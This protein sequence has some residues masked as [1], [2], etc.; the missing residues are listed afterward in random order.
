MRSRPP[1]GGI[2]RLRRTTTWGWGIRALLPIVL[3]LAGCGESSSSGGDDFRVDIGAEGVPAADKLVLTVK[4]ETP[5]GRVVVSRSA[6][7][8]NGL[9]IDRPVQLPKDAVPPGEGPLYVHAV[10]QLEGRAV[11]VTDGAVGDGAEGRFTLKVVPLVASCD[12]DGDTYRDCTNVRDECCVDVPEATRAAVIDCVDDPA[13]IAPPVTPDGKRRRAEAAHGFAPS[14]NA[15]DYATCGNGLDDDCRGGDLACDTETDADGDQ[16]PIA[17]D[18]NDADDQIHVGAYDRPGDGVDQDCDGI[19][20][21][22]TDEDEDGWLADDPDEARRDCADDDP[23]RFPAA[24]EVPCDGIDQDCD[25]SDPCPDMGDMDADGVPAAVDCDDYDAGA[26]PGARERCG[27]GIDQDCNGTDLACA[28]GDTDRD[29]RVGADDCDEGNAFVHR[30][31]PEKCGDGV[32]QDCDGAD[33]PCAGVRDGDGDGFAAPADCDDGAAEVHPFADELCN[34]IDDDCDGLLDEGSPLRLAAGDVPRE[35]TCG[36]EGGT[37]FLGRNVCTRDQV[38]GG[39]ARPAIVCLGQEP[40]PEV[41]DGLDNDCDGMSDE[42]DQEDG[43]LSDEGLEACGPEREMGGCR[44]GTLFCEN[45]SLSRCVGAVFP[46][47]EECNGA[48]D[49]CDGRVDNDAAGGALTR[50]CFDGAEDLRNQGLC[51]DG[52]QRCDNGRFGACEGQV[53]PADETCDTRDEDCDGAADDEVLADCYSFPPETRGVGVCAA[54]RRLCADGVFGECEGEVGPS[55]EQCNNRDDDCDGRIDQ[56]AERCF[57]GDPAVIDVGR[58]RAGERACM[59][60]NWTECR[61]QIVPEAETCD[62]EDDDCDGAIDEDF[63]LLTDRQNCNQCGR[64]CGD[65]EECCQ[66]R[67][68]RLDTAEN[69]GACGNSCDRRADRCE[70]GPDSARCRC[71]DGDACPDGQRCVDGQCRCLSNDDCGPDQL[72]CNGACQATRVEAGP[73]GEPA[74]CAACGDGGCNPRFAEHCEERVC[75][76]GDTDACTGTTVCLQDDDDGE[77]L[78]FGCERDR[79]CLQAGTICCRNACVPV[80][81]DAQCEACGERCSPTAADRCVEVGRNAEPPVACVCGDGRAPCAA[82]TPF[83]IGGAC[84]E[85]RNDADCPGDRSRCVDNVCRECNPADH[86]PCGADQLCCNFRCQATGPT[87]GEQCEACGEACDQLSTNRCTGRDCRCGNNPE[88]SGATPICDDARGVCVN[89]RN[90]TDCQGNPNGGQ[91]VN[92]VCRTCDP[93]GHDGCAGNQLCCARGGVPRCE[94]TGS[95]QGDE[96]EACDVACAQAPTNACNGRS[97]GCGNGPPCGGGTPICDDGRSLCVECLVD[98]HCNNRPGG[99]Q[100]VN[101]VCRPCDPGDHAGCGNDQLCC[102]FQCQATSGAVNGQC[103]ACGQACGSSADTC[104]NRD[105][106]CG[107]AAGAAACGDPSPF[108]QNGACQRCRN[109][110]DCAGNELCC[111]GACVPTGAEAPLPCTACGTSC[112]ATNSNLCTN[113]GCRCGVNNACGGASP[114]CNDAAGRC[115]QCLADVDCNGRAGTPECVGETCRAC[116]PAT[117]AGCAE[118]GAM[119][120]CDAGN[121]TCRTCNG[122]AECVTR[123]GNQNECV[124]GRCRACEP[125]TN[126]GCSDET[127]TCDPMSFTCRACANN[128]ECTAGQQCVAGACVGCNPANG[129]GCGPDQPICEAGTFVCRTCRNDN[130]CGARTGP[131]DQCVLG[132]CQACDTADHAGCA[133]NQLCCNFQCQATGAAAPAACQAC[134]VSCNADSTNTCNGRACR[135]GNN[136]PCSGQTA[137]CDD[138]RGVCVNCRDDDDC[139]GARGECVSN[140]CEACDP[141]DDSGCA[142]NSNTPICAGATPACRACQNDA[143]CPNNGQCLADG[144]CRPCDPTNAAGCGEGSAAPICDAANATCRACANDGECAAR[145][146]TLDWCVQGE[147]EACKPADNSGC[148]AAS[149]TPICDAASRTCRAC[150]NDVDCNGNP[151]GG[152]CVAGACKPCDPGDYAGCDAASATPVCNAAFACVGCTLDPQCVTSPGN[153]DQCVAGGRCK[154]CDT[155]DHAGCVESSAT[156]ICGA[157]NTC[158][159]CEEDDE[160][161]ARPGSRDL[162]VDGACNVCDPDDSRGC[163]A[164]VCS[165]QQCVACTG[166]P[167]CDGHQN[168]EVCDDGLCVECADHADCMGRL[169]TANVCVN[170]A[171]DEDCENAELG[172]TCNNGTCQ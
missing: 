153:A 170:C 139:G 122:D 89:C 53:V 15:G 44:R 54:G 28:E 61:G 55:P 88:C 112:N 7:L 118:N 12:R 162:C 31:A 168:G 116:D 128:N 156:P 30:G 39:P 129:A 4:R 58:C 23:R 126:A 26:F 78:C 152:E 16:H 143:E 96:C 17:E 100:C 5:S 98:G 14:E 102:N 95:R 104:R 142:P 66:G 92:N 167:D 48:D 77:Y 105:C 124:M 117:S 159:A 125:G 127:P 2:R 151:N 57:E 136:A 109:N 71:G 130:E 120:I 1:H 140:A 52:I 138:P 150:N 29:G 34:L 18:C 69:C 123:N 38:E 79:D 137:F 35:P 108:C 45:G 165:A 10:A 155:A 94:A 36:L 91:C 81:A 47:E 160:C 20:G 63:D 19:D 67:C 99:S 80:N 49:D 171:T 97:C 73:N 72:C 65:A 133:A 161:A 68:R 46:A 141:A 33:L 37:C 83:C 8:S 40:Q 84:E 106:V 74:Q 114:V 164:Q 13:G 149:A 6:S 103:E 169:C 110:N 32:D 107:G 56:F 3:A 146:G 147:C 154:V 87:A 43:R 119:P 62:L 76:C 158:V 166:D 42:P 115:V 93:N 163:V 157:G 51:R 144:R 135:C 131:E 75:K 50:A 172:D 113:R 24:A 22:G 21:F 41:C 60:G 64:A 11:A 90:D 148:N 121:F 27:D 70:V 82:P 86:R 85:C 101:N 111:N 59:G 132:R 145:P 134:G 25:A 9:L